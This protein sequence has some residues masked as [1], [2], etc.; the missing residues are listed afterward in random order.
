MGEED[1]GVV[2]Q[3][4]E[5]V[6]RERGLVDGPA[7][8]VGVGE[9]GLHEDVPAAGQPGDDLLGL[10]L[11]AAPVHGHPVAGGGEG[12]RDGGADAAGAPGD[13]DRAVAHA[14]AGATAAR[15]PSRSRSTSSASV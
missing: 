12:L 3:H 6:E 9:V 10:S 13:E 8:G 1:A 5:A 14:A 15:T 7:H 4:V 11:R 2:D